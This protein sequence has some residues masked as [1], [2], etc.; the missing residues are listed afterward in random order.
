MPS[1]IPR[2]GFDADYPPLTYEDGLR[3]MGPVRDES[4]NR[5]V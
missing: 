2:F 1:S 5:P 4:A 3:Q